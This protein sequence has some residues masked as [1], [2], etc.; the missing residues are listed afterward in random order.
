MEEES[1]IIKCRLKG[2][3]FLT[4]DVEP[5][6]PPYQSNSTHGIEEGLPWIVDMLDKKNLKAT[7]FIVGKLADDYPSIIEEIANK[8]HEIG[9]HGY[10]HSRLDKLP[11]AEAI[12]NIKRSIESLSVYQDVSSF[13]APNLQ[14]PRISPDDYLSMG[15]KVDSSI[16]LYKDRNYKGPVK[17]K[18]LLILPATAT[19]S[20]IRLPR[21]LAIK[22]TLNS[23]RD[24]HVLFYHPWEF[25]HIRRKPI[26]RPDIWLRTGSY[27]RNM[28][29]IVIDEA[30]KKGFQFLTVKE[31]L[32][33]VECLD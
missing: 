6:A 14:P 21:V 20:T 25:T 5:D 3:V 23:R 11:R 4:F 17:K 28:L 12:R 24:F 9:S 19:S 15:I 30:R 13:R 22:I 33:K 1:N 8:G 16:A 10:D 7:F 18:E 2:T 26:Y 31:S 27:A 32:N 29:E